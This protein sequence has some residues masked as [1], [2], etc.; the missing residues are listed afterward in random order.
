MPV[1]VFFLLILSVRLYCFYYDWIWRFGTQNASR[2]F[3]LCCMG[4]SR[5]RDH[6][7][8][9]LGSALEPLF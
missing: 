7:D 4:F 2:S 1:K 5:R 9:H 8:L 3:D 6:D